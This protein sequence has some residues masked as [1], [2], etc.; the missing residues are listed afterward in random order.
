[1]MPLAE[2]DFDVKEQCPECPRRVGENC[3]DDTC[4]FLRGTAAVLVKTDNM[5]R[6]IAN[7][8]PNAS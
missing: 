4:F 8:G 2:A 7:R 3:G 6:E 5:L 1:M